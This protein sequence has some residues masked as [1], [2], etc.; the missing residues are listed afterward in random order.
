MHLTE[1]T[2]PA[3]ETDFIQ[4]NVQL[5]K[6]E[7]GYVRPLDKDIRDVFD[8]KKN[9]AYRFGKTVRWVLRDGQH[10]QAAASFARYRDVMKRLLA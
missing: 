1:V 10:S 2:T 7:P 4:A 5:N 3:H 6:A 8:P 9:K